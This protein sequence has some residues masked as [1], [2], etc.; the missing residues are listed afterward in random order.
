MAPVDPGDA[1]GRLAESARGWHRIQLAVLGFVG[2]CGALWGGDGSAAPTWLQQA[3]GVLAVLAFALACLAIVLVGRVAYR[4][5]GPTPGELTS[6]TRQLRTGVRTT[7]L[8]LAVLVAA[9]LPAWW[10]ASDDATTIEVSDASGQTWCGQLTDAPPGIIGL[11]TD[12]GT[13]GLQLDH[14]SQIRQV[15]GC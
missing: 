13:L 11:V 4:L 9:T 10:P 14:L 7:Y 5:D 15:S 8:A 1:A 2:L 12:S 6:S 3:A